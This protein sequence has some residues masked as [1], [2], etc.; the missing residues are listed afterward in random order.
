MEPSQFYTGLVADLYAPLKSMS[1][2][3]APYARFIAH[4]GQPALELGCGDGEPLL[5]LVA[6]GLDVEGVDSSPDMLEGCR[7]NATKR[8]VQVTLHHQ[9]MESL[10]LPRR[11]RS[12]FL[13][14]RR[15]ICWP[16][17]SMQAPP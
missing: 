9:S 15:S 10:S 16:T 4:S 5:D 8:G 17:I 13:P 1:N 12:I 2:N 11:Y 7:L 6:Q 3:P 14:G